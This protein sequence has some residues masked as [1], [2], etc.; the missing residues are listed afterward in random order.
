MYATVCKLCSF[1]FYRITNKREKICAACNRIKKR[2]WHIKKKYGI[3]IDDYLKLYKK[4]KGKCAICQAKYPVLHIDHD[5]DTKAIR[6][7]LCSNCNTGIGLLQEK[8]S[9][10]ASA[11][12]YIEKAK[13]K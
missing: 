5:H 9:I 7:L 1:E 3:E 13:G 11:I 10:L 2:T 4:Q 8:T 6:G 12:Q